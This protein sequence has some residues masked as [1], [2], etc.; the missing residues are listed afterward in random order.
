LTPI[1]VAIRTY[2]SKPATVP[3][4]SGSNHPSGT[5]MRSAGE[6]ADFKLLVDHTNSGDLEIAAIVF[7][8]IA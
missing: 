4:E 6:K 2:S 1:L 8:S 3:L 5:G 7:F